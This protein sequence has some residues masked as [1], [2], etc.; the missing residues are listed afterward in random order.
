MRIVYTPRNCTGPEYE[1]EADRHGNYSI[2]LEGKL[3]RRV[4]AL[5]HYLGRPLWGSRKL[6][7]DAI[8]D[9]MR[10]IDRSSAQAA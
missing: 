6:E 5:P 8:E 10:D 4:G 1:I 9:A 3:V 2:R 7:A